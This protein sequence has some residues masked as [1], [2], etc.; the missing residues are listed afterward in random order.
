MIILYS[1]R[2][3]GVD[4]LDGEACRQKRLRRPTAHE[5]QALRPSL[6]IINALMLARGA[7]SLLHG[8]ASTTDWWTEIRWNSVFI[9]IT[10]IIDIFRVA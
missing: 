1:R 10:I 9:I 5:H 6:G 8:A 7:P 3:A 4:M 2:S